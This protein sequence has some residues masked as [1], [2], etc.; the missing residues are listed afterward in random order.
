MIYA[1]FLMRNDFF[2]PGALMYGYALKKQ[3]IKDV[4]CFVTDDISKRAV[5]FL[6]AVFDRVIEI[7]A[8]QV[9]H[10]NQKGRRD[11]GD[12]FTRFE[13]LKYYDDFD[14]LGQ[15][16]LLADSDI[17]P[18]RNYKELANA[19]SPSAIINEKDAYTT[20]QEN[21]QYVVD[22]PTLKTGQ[23]HWHDRYSDYLNGAQIPA[24]IT[25]RVK[26]DPTNL[27]MNTSLWIFNT[28]MHDYTSIQDDLRMPKTQ[29]MV[30][31][32]NWPEMQ[33]ITQKWSGHWHTLDI[34]YASFSGYPR[35]DLV[36]GIHFAGQKPWAITHKS[37]DHYSRF[38]DFRMWQSLFLTMLEDTPIL[39]TYPK[40]RRLA[41]VFEE[42]FHKMPYTEEEISHTPEWV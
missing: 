27:G 33:Y 42:K 10:P 41:D 16:I 40:L 23:W 39:Q 12:L 32:F 37:F 24:H 7:D 19:P 38:K 36:N 13:V 2:V 26:D 30:G 6:H 14:P 35:L 29:A 11:R 17:L 15:K 31:T 22:E 28:N 21:G 34:K 4:Y 3:G 8:V 18:L 1:T 20:R 5:E 9:P 25:D